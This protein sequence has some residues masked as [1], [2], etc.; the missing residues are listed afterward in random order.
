[1][2]N[3][4]MT[5]ATALTT[6]IAV[7]NTVEGVSPETI[8][9]L[10]ALKASLDKKNAAPR[11]L[12]AQQKKN[13]V[14]RKELVEF[15]NENFKDDG[16]TVTDVL[17]QCPAVEGDSNQHVSAILRKAVKNKELSKGSV[18]RRTYFAPFGV[19]P[20]VETEEAEV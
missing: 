19:Y 3:K 16:F 15:I 9:K 7:L 10:A 20:H 4:K 12:T 1:M 8:E 2:T 14:L 18:K 6:A 5:Y 17:K 13:E 11:T